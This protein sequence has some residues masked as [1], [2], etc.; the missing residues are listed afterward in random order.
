MLPFE[1]HFFDH[2]IIF[3]LGI[4]FPVRALANGADILQKLKPDTKAKIAIYYGNSMVMWGFTAL[5]ILVWGLSGRS[6][7]YLGLGY[8][9]ELSGQAFWIVVIFAALYL[10]DFFSELRSKQNAKTEEAES[11]AFLPVN[12]QEYLHYIVMAFSAG[13]TEEILFRAYFIHYMVSVTGTSPM[14]I[15]LAICLPAVVFGIVHLYQ[16]WKAVVKIIAM[17]VFFGLI[18]L[19]LRNLWALIVLHVVVDLVGGS[20][21]WL[22]AAKKPTI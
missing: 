8:P 4:V 20:I 22:Q 14:G 16:G 12:R 5:V 9:P 15:A 2:L 19:Q 1:P 6:L 21:A 18:Y 13:V 7:T 10:L 17:A 11:I 3:V